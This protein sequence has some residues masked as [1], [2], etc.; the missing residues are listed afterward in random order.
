M[1]GGQG[2]EVVFIV[3]AQM[4]RRAVKQIRNLDCPQRREKGKNHRHEREQK[5][6]LKGILFQT[7]NDENG[8]LMIS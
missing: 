7:Q 2:I 8:F 5:T 1:I 4:E 6:S 3:L